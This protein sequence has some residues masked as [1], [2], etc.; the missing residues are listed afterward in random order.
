MAIRESL[1]YSVRAGDDERPYFEI[2]DAYRLRWLDVA[3]EPGELKAVAYKDGEMIGEAVVKTAGETARLALT[4]DRTRMN[5]DGM[6]LCYITIE[7]VD[8]ED[9]LCPWAMDMLEF[10]V[11]GAARLMGIAN[12][13]QRGHDVFTDANHPLFYGKA[14]AVIRSIPGTSGNAV[15]T[16][17][18]ENGLESS[19][20]VEF[21]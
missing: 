9:V 19:V 7:M 11:E 17:E 13:H 16:V 8:S 14:V 2:V 15:V 6:D 4:P 3:Y 1:D 12:G 18:S 20:T 5:A 10:T 21:L